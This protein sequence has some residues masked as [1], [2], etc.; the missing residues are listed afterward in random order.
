VILE[1]TA[2]HTCTIALGTGS[3]RQP[4]G[5]TEE[6]VL[7][8]EGERALFDVPISYPPCASQVFSEGDAVL[9]HFAGHDRTTPT[10]IGFIRE[11][12]PCPG[13]RQSWAQLR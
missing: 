13:G 6:L 4:R 12:T 7:D 1:I 10:V 3:V 9:V 8:A 2:G 11:P 5:V